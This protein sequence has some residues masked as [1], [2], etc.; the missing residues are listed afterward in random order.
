M[1]KYCGRYMGFLGIRIIGNQT[2][3]SAVSGNC[4]TGEDRVC[5]ELPLLR[6]GFTY[7]QFT[8]TFQEDWTVLY[9]SPHP[10]HDLNATIFVL[11][12]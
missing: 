7:A 11:A 3:L 9:I 2:S 6:G 5:L 1:E 8:V 10:G 4:V 12:V